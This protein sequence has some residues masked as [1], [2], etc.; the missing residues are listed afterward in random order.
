MLRCRA[1]GLLQGTTVVVLQNCWVEKCWAALLQGCSAVWLLRRRSAVPQ[2]PTCKRDVTGTGL[3]HPEQ[4]TKFIKRGTP[5]I[6]F[7]D[8]VNQLADSVNQLAD[9]AIQ[10]ADSAIQSRANI[11]VFLCV[12]WP[13]IQSIQRPDSVNQAAD[14]VNQ[15]ADSAIQ[16]FGDSVRL[17]DSL[18]DSVNQHN[19]TRISESGGGVIHQATPDGPEPLQ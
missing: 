14:S 19:K 3:S 2:N 6:R 13:P 8:S 10:L 16:R 7:S 15:A 11:N 5:A 9:S 12:W 17:S 1:P 18:N 4:T